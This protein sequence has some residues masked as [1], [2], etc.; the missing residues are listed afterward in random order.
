MFPLMII[1]VL[2]GLFF[3]LIGWLL[4]KYP[5]L[6]SGY[7]T[8]S[9]SQK[10]Q[11]D[12]KSLS[13]MMQI[14]MIYMGILTAAGSITFSLLKMPIAVSF[15]LLLVPIAGVIL[16]VLKA[17]KYSKLKSK[18]SPWVIG[19][20]ILILIGV[21]SLLFYGMKPATISFDKNQL[22][23]SGMYGVT[24]E[25]ALIENV[26]LLDTIPEIKMRTNGFAMGSVRKGWFRLEGWGRCKLIIH[27]N[28]APYIF[29]EDSNGGIT[30]FKYLD[31]EKTKE[32]YDEIVLQLQ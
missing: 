15:T 27:G 30:L 6:I 22:T 8:L 12:V 29:I 19:F 20:T 11:I 9:A 1:G 13:K 21:L 4:P 5:N 14:H 23:I 16:M 26:Q 10:K 32:A 25:R 18:A 7:N 28:K 24:I 31:T 3:I 17:Q 2:T